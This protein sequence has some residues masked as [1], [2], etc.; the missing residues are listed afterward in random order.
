MRKQLYS[1][2]GYIYFH[3]PNLKLAIAEVLT[4]SNGVFQRKKDCSSN[5][6][7]PQNCAKKKILLFG[8]VMKRVREYNRI[9]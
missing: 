5:S 1:M 9:M 3:L 2:E 8:N 4:K 6:L 7:Q